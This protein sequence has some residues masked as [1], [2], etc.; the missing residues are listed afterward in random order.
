MPQKCTLQNGQRAHF[1][2][3]HSLLKSRC[4]V[5]WVCIWNVLPPQALKSALTG[6]GISLPPLL[7]RSSRTY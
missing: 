3:M 5:L 7:P 6:A 2:A 4:S 1:D